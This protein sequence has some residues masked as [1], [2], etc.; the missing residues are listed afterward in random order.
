MTF[1]WSHIP[2]PEG[3]I[4][5]LGRGA[6][7]FVSNIE[8]GVVDVEDENAG[9]YTVN[10]EKQ[11]EIERKDLEA[12]LF[13][14]KIEERIRLRNEKY[15]SYKRKNEDDEKTLQDIVTEDYKDLKASL[16]TISAAEWENIPDDFSTSERRP[17]WELLTFASGRTVTG[18]Y[19]DSELYKQVYEVDNERDTDLKENVKMLSYSRAKLQV[20]QNSLTKSIEFDDSGNKDF[21]SDIDE[22]FSNMMKQHQE[23][24]DALVV[25]TSMTKENPCNPLGW[26]MRARLE[27]KIGKSKKARSH[28][29]RALDYCPESEDIILEIIRLLKR[30]EASVIIEDKLKNEMASNE[31]I[32]IAYADLSENSNEKILKL[33]EGVRL[34][35]KSSKLRL[36]LAYADKKNT[37]HHLKEAIEEIKDDKDLF[38]NGICLS[39]NYEDSKYFFDQSMNHFGN[40]ADVYIEFA[41]AD[42]QF[43]NSKNVEQ[44][45]QTAFKT[46]SDKRWVTIAQMSAQKGINDV[47]R[48]IIDNI[49]V[50]LAEE[51]AKSSENLGLLEL[52]SVCYNKLAQQ[53]GRWDLVLDFL[54]RHKV[55]GT[56][57]ILLEDAAKIVIEK[58][59]GDSEKVM[60]AAK[61][62]PVEERIKILKDINQDCSTQNY[63]IAYEIAKSYAGLQQF[64]EAFQYALS[65]AIHFNSPELYIYAEDIA[66]KLDV[67]LDVY[68]QGTRLFPDQPLLWLRYSRHSDSPEVVLHESIKKCPTTAILYIELIK[69]IK[70]KLKRPQ[71]MALFEKACYKCSREAIIWLF[72]AEFVPDVRRE[73]IL[74]KAKQSGVT[75]PE[76]IW[77]KQIETRPQSERYTM[78][79]EQIEELGEK[80]ELLLLKAISEWRH[81]SVDKARSTFEKLSDDYPEY[82]DAWIFR[83]KFE[84][85][86]SSDDIMDS[87][88]KK[89]QKANIRNGFIWEAMMCDK[90][91]YGLDSSNAIIEIEKNIS[92]PIL[93]D[94][95]IFGT[96][97]S[98]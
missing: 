64:Q 34:L 94:T 67:N 23:V 46:S 56:D 71:I 53:C 36:A 8:F 62:L 29:K 55:D 97:L 90:S 20:F 82:G 83:L 33:T 79:N 30:N 41:R 57:Q 96:I 32:W 25:Y 26:I 98:L 86:N 15:N 42:E 13:Y 1:P 76:L 69:I 68:S 51:G 14:S 3:Y 5:G 63:M 40:D 81:G 61:Y 91:I 60:L 75:Q 43:N 10:S 77:A 38:I 58:N 21:F 45:I 12:D 27:E 9:N 44:I 18:D 39:Q 6:K 31:R 89:V 88:W 2:K 66:E 74:E 19:Q 95:S 16:R 70:G 65:E 73:K 72:F 78:I 37:I 7:G 87:Y 50:E 35:P 80:P 4:P 54:D 85:M 52:A 22:K 84:R 24:S 59:R 93:T 28:I 17:K 47:A 49:P 11:R 92:D 48:S